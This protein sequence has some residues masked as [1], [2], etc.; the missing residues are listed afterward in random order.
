MIIDDKRKKEIVLNF[1]N[2]HIQ[3]DI[4]KGEY[5]LNI[6]P[7]DGT[8]RIEIKLAVEITKKIIHDEEQVKT[9]ID[10]GKHND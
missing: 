2:M 7:S 4:D 8:S 6:T 5:I 3:A 9:P 1:I 10:Y